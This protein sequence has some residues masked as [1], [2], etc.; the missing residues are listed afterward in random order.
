MFTSSKHESL[1]LLFS[2]SELSGE[3][4]CVQCSTFS[5]LEGTVSSVE[6][7]P[8]V[9][10]SFLPFVLYSMKTHLSF[11][12]EKQVETPAYAEIKRKLIKSLKKSE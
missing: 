11:L 2:C 5:D 10:F 8:L 12:G 6:L 7:P 9:F 4:S 3:F 1:L